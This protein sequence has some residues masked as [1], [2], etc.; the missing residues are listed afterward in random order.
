MMHNSIGR[1][2]YLGVQFR[3]IRWQNNRIRN[4][5]RRIITIRQ[6]LSNK[7]IKTRKMII[8]VVVSPFISMLI[9]YTNRTIQIRFNSSNTNKYSSNRRTWIWITTIRIVYRV[10]FR[11]RRSRSSRSRANRRNWRY[12]VG[13]SRR[14]NQ[15][16]KK[17]GMSLWIG[18]RLYLEH[19]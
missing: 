1:V 2:F 18:T 15:R 5:Y 11:C 12:L 17:Q 16:Q 6:I 19:L 9:T 13:R 8:M 10:T 7:T 4:N 3:F 14:E